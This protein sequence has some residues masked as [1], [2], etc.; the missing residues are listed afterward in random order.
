V[1]K[2]VFTN[3]LQVAVVVRDLEASM[4]TYWEDYGIGPWEVY[5][6]NPDTL[7]EMTRDG[8]PAE[9]AARLALT[10]VGDV[11]L[12]LIQPLDEDSIY[13]DFLRERGEGLHH[14]GLDVP[15]YAKALGAL[16]SKGLRNVTGGLYNGVRYAY[17]STD[18]DLGF[19]SEIFDWPA[20][21]VQ[22][23]DAVYPP[24]GE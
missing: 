21:R 9:Y 17:L 11:S 6:F 12:E 24:P 10:N 4:R 7:D 19:V 20:D 5:E 15:D 22:Q 2:P 23:P 14:L 16:E 1:T 18:R 3:V 8:E 13:A